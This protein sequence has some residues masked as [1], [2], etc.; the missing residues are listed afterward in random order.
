MSLP[1]GPGFMGVD[2]YLGCM[3]RLIGDRPLS[4]TSFSVPDACEIYANMV[5]ARRFDERALALQRRGWMSGY[6]PF[7]GQEAAQ[8]GAAFAMRPDDWLAPTYRSNALQL[9]RD[10]PPSDILLFRRGR[11]E[12]H[13]DHDVPVFPQSVPI[14]TQLP[15]ATGVGMAQRYAGTDDA[16]LAC[17]GDGA[18]SEGDFHE[19][20]NFAGVFDAPVVFFCENN[21]W[22]IS[23]PDRRQTASDTIAVKAEAYGFEGVRVDGNDPLAVAETVEAALSSARE[24]DP[25]LVEALTYRQG[26]HTTADD[27]SRYRPETP[28]LPEWRTRDPLERYEEY[29]REAGAVD[30]EFVEQ[31]REAADAELDR[32]VAVAEEVDPADPADLFDF[33]YADPSPHLRAQ[34]DAFLASLD[35]HDPNELEH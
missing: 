19:A 26:A 2:C 10:V 12:Y 5:R 29:L 20:L 14:A 23:M 16:V 34:R 31:A 24:G 3:H 11:A 18:T 27:P 33:A 28:E 6:P 35:D 30:D 21:G 13:S 8:I 15:I 1:A 7:R 17:F 9:A 25:V 32:A 4:E 22:A